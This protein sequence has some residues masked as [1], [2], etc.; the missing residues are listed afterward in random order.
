MTITSISGNTIGISPA[1]NFTHYGA[2]SA[3][4]NSYGTLDMRTGVAHLTRK[5]KIQAGADTG[6]GFRVQ[7]YGFMDGDIS[8]TGAVNLTGVQFIG[9]GQADTEYAALDFLDTLN[10]PYLSLV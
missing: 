5:I 2:S 1:L 6:Y 8:R 7:V 3:L 4:T 9:G 10:N